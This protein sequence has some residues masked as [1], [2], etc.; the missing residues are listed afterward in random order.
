MI[1]HLRKTL[2]EAGLSAVGIVAADGSWK[3][4]KD[5]LE[6]KDLLD[7]VSVIGAHYPGTTT[8]AEAVKTGKTLW[9][10]ED[11]STFNDDIGKLMSW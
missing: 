9:A 4:A 11:Y 8:S 6:D 10:S 7:A 3:I 5:M 2:D 1:Q